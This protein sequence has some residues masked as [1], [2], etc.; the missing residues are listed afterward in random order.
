MQYYKQCTMTKNE[1][2]QVAWIPE[3]FAKV[4]KF[5]RL[6]DDNGWEVTSVGTH[7]LN[8]QYI[9][10]HEREYLRHRRVTDI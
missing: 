8:G 9:M 5:L 2:S 1:T 10:D 3:E 6:E 7:R 4:G